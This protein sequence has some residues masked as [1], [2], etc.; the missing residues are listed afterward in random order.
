MLTF[1]FTVT[2]HTIC[3]RGVF[4]FVDFNITVFTFVSVD[5]ITTKFETDSF[6]TF[7]TIVT[8]FTAWMT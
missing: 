2:L 8:S 6:Y 3:T 7:A 1:E 5:T 4:T